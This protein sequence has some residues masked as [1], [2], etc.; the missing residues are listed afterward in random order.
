[1]CC[2]P[3]PFYTLLD[4][5]I[6]LAGSRLFWRVLEMPF[7]L[8]YL[9]VTDSDRGYTGAQENVSRLTPCSC[10]SPVCGYLHGN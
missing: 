1:M 7:E 9:R 5:S 4:G 8:Y 10:L 3:A 6:I 2:P